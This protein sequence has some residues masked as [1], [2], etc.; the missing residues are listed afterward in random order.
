MPGEGYRP[1]IERY[2]KTNPVITVRRH[3]RSISYCVPN[4]LVLGRVETVLEKEPETIAWIEGF[5]ADDV[6]VDVG[7]NVGLYAL[8]AAVVAGARVFAFEPES[9][10]FALL[11]RNVFV[12]R[13]AARLTP[14]AVALSDATGFDLLHVGSFAPGQSCHSFAEPVDDRLRER[15]FPFTQGCAATTLDRLVA[16][17]VVAPPRHLKID[18][19]GFE[20]KVVAGAGATLADGACR[21]VMI[22]VNRDLAPHREMVAELAAMGFTHDPAQANRDMAKDG[23][24]RGVGNILFRR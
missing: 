11:C 21:S 8:W 20:H 1:A 15:Q 23:R 6:F 12:N 22:E 7:A 18:V 13:A 4:R 17:G 5:A 19:D 16:D 2:E 14:F 10:N 3:E 24:F 9:Q